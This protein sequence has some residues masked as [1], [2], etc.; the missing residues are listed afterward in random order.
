MIATSNPVVYAAINAAIYSYQITQ[1]QTN[2]LYAGWETKGWDIALSF[3]PRL[4]ATNS[5]TF[6]VFRRD[7]IV[8]PMI[9]G[10]ERACR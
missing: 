9:W 7:S 8:K 1:G 3:D 2:P 6:W 10:E 4:G 5:T